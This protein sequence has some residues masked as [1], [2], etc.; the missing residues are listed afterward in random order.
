MIAVRKVCSA[1]LSGLSTPAINQP[2]RLYSLSRPISY[3]K[4]VRPSSSGLGI[5]AALHDDSRVAMAVAFGRHSE[6]AP[7]PRATAPTGRPHQAEPRRGPAAPGQAQDRPPIR[8]HAAPA[9]PR[10]NERTD[11]PGAR[12][13]PGWL[14]TGGVAPSRAM[15][16]G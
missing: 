6:P 15:A 13:R 3:R 11:R 1:M 2:V 4:L 8:D 10:S 7:A 12:W 5:G 14:R 9:A 16:R